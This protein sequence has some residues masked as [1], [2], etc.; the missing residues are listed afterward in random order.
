[1]SALNRCTSGASSAI[2]VVHMNGSQA[3]IAVLALLVV[4]FLLSEGLHRW[5]QEGDEQIARALEAAEDESLAIATEV[6][7]PYV[8]AG[9]RVPVQRVTNGEDLLPT[10]PYTGPDPA[11]GGDP[12]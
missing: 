9:L 12:L 5:L 7:A 3:V 6:S 1:M 11:E 10:Y 2:G 8:G 4:G